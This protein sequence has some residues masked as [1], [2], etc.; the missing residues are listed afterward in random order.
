MDKI[1][2]KRWIMLYYSISI[3]VGISSAVFGPSLIKLVEQTNS[4]LGEISL[5]FPTRA[6]SYL[7]GSWIAGF[8]FDK[9]RGHR[10]LAW[11]LPFV[12]ISLL[13]IPLLKTP[14][15]LIF[16]SAI[17]ALATGLVDVGCNSLLFRVPEIDIAPAMSGLHF[18]FGLGSFLAPMTLAGSLNL[19]QGIQ[20][21]Y[22]GLGLASV[23]ILVQFINLPE[24]AS[25]Q[26]S[27]SEDR[28]PGKMKPP[29]R[30]R[31]IWVIALFFFAFVGVEVGYGDWLSAYAIKTGL[32]DQ[33]AAILM[34][35]TYW[36]A[37]TF[38]RLLSIPL[39]VRVEPRKILLADVAGA[40]IG[41]GM[42]F[43]FPDQ[44]AILWLGTIILGFSVASMFPAMLTF[45][46]SL[47]P[48]TGKATSIFFISGSVGSIF[49]PW[50]IGRSV[51]HLGPTFIVRVLF[52][53]LILAAA[54]FLVLMLVSKK[55]AVN[56][57]GME[58][59]SN[60]D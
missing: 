18:F 24:P 7:A 14:L 48:M 9:Y 54:V 57:A 50:I 42:V 43:F 35:S 32:A 25:I 28:I 29:K 19:F 58:Q 27:S 37:F 5:V 31:V 59:S 22:W 1:I 46:E 60:Q 41:L 52:L 10:L 11:I 17:M 23:L 16:I 3:Y 56:T 6:F 4:S 21:G 8:L 26:P 36:G 34:T 38:S 2:K 45:A 49:L 47:L 55:P 44:L 40:V 20:A 13:L 53:A 12:A 33:Q 30:P 39:A 15:T 51:G